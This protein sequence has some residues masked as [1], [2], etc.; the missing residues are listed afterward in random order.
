MLVFCFYRLALQ[1]QLKLLQ[2]LQQTQS[3]SSLCLSGSIQIS[4][5]HK[6]QRCI[7]YLK[8]IID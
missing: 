7:N 8:H 5:T 4:A 3:L 6:E 1:K 2:L